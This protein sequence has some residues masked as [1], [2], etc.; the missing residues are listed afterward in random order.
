MAE[1]TDNWRMLFGIFDSPWQL[2]G[3]AGWCLLMGWGFRI[4]LLR[5]ALSLGVLGVLVGVAWVFRDA[6][7]AALVYAPLAV[8]GVVSVIS[9]GVV[10]RSLES[11]L[12]YTTKLVRINHA[13]GLLLGLLIG[14]VVWVVLL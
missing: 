4:G 2:L 9:I 12:G 6:E 10:G 8:V 5:M 11:R 7:S 14:V 13:G 1:A 3:L